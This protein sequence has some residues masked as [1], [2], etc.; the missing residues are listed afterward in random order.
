MGQYLFCRSPLQQ[1]RPA[2][3]FTMVTGRV[4]LNSDQ[5]IL[6]L[7]QGLFPFIRVY[8]SIVSDNPDMKNAKQT[9]IGYPDL[10]WRWCRLEEMQPLQLYDL[11]ALRE[12]IFVVEQSCAY[13]ELDGLDK[14]AEHLLVTQ[15]ET[16]VSCLRVLPPEGETAV[17]R[18]GRVAVSSDWRKRGLARS[19]VQN[20]IDRIRVS[21]PSSGI[22]LDAQ[23]YLE[24]F[25][26]SLGFLVCGDEFLEDGI[27]HIPMQM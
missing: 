27:P 14:A 18:I 24:E 7:D 3:V 16:V 17:A 6:V 11:L 10:Y 23:T 26:L 1:C 2:G 5:Y 20:A 12:A 19:M 9:R 21:Y 15:N 8:N 4:G 25:Y 22:C 13:L